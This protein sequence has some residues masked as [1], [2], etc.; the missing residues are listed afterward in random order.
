M[1]R[2]SGCKR[3]LPKSRFSKNQAYCVDCAREYQWRIKF[4]LTPEDVYKIYLQQNGKCAICGKEGKQNQNLA[5]DHDKKTGSI[6][7]LLCSKCNTGIG[8]LGD[9]LEGLMEAVRYLRK[10]EEEI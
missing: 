4:G 3:I 1:K 8:L 10:F 5:I 2:C 9:N 6:R 7:G